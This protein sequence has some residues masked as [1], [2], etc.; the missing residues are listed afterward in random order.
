MSRQKRGVTGIE[1]FAGGQYQFSVLS[2]QAW[3]RSSGASAVPRNSGGTTFREEPA[4]EK[5]TKR[6]DSVFFTAFPLHVS[7]SVFFQ[8]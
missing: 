7:D 8:S 5:N 3:L 4:L 6:G 2:F 1:Y